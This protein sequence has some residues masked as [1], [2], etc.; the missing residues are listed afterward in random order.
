MFRKAKDSGE[1]PR[2]VLLFARGYDE[3]SHLRLN[4]LPSVHEV[5]ERLPDFSGRFPRDLIVNEVRVAIA[6]MRAGLIAGRDGGAAT[7]EEKVIAGACG[8][9]G[10]VA[11]TGDQ[12]DGRRSAYQPWARAA[13]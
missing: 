13:R 2:R 11:P 12:C 1:I 7:I 5:L 8:P 3:S 4:E 6:D 9:R 10:N